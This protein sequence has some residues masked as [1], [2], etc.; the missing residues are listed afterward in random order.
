MTTYRVATFVTVEASDPLDAAMKAFILHE[1]MTPEDYEV[2]NVT[3]GD[4]IAEEIQVSHDQKDKA[5]EFQR[6]G[7]LFNTTNLK[8]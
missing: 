5:R 8:D 6:Q 3:D 7:K 1:E 2:V 4:I